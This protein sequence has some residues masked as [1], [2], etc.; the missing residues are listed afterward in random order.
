MPSKRSKVI[1][2]TFTTAAL[3]GE[4]APEHGDP[5]DG[6]DGIGQRVDDGAVGCGRVELGEVLGDG[7]TRDGQAV[8]VEE[9]GLEEV[10]HD[11]GHAADRVEI[12]HVVATGRSGVGD[13]GHALGDAVE[14]LELQLDLG[15]VG[16]GEQVQHRVGGAAEGHHDGDGVLEGL[17]RHD[18]AGPEPGSSRRTTASPDA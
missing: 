4:R 15:L 12:G 8:A 10:A 18:L 1:P 5:A 9:A 16:H 3:G 7:A 6:V 13:V 2:A 11:H 14:V 17:L